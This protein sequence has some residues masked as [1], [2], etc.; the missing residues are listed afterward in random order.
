M[1]IYAL[2]GPGA[3]TRNNRPR[4]S[5]QKRWTVLYLRLRSWGAIVW[6]CR[7]LR[8]ILGSMNKMRLLPF[9]YEL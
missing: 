2:T 6:H 3:P 1:M 9:P 8:I 7:V 4:S 5:S